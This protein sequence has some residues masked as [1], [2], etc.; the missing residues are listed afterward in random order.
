MN[1]KILVLRGGPSSEYEVSLK[2]GKSVIEKLSNKYE[3]TDVVI[4]KNG[5]WLVSGLIVKPEVICRNVDCVFNAMHGEYGEDGQVQEILEVLGIPFTGPKRLGAVLSMN[6][7]SSKEVYKQHG[8]KTPLHK[9]LKKPDTENEEAGIEV[10]A[11]LVFRTFPMPLIIKPVG[12]G[13]SVGIEIVKTYD[14]LVQTMVKLYEQYD[15]L[16]IEEYIEGREATVGVI[17]R[18]RDDKVYAL[19]PIEIKV[20]DDYKFFDYDAKYSGGTEEISPGNFSKDESEAMQEVARLAH[21]VLG[22]RHYS[23]SDFIIHPKR[24]IYILETNSLPGLT[25]ESLLPKSFEPVG[26]TYEEFLDHVITLAL[27]E[28]A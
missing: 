23:R 24:G 10:Q 3:V 15:E 2:T 20:S 13:S 28:S 14:D 21:E 7:A 17:D 16:L 9:V 6:K 18:F 19:L 5:D 4:D 1:K 11:M 12:L 26:S 25:E 27:E 22:L 8:I